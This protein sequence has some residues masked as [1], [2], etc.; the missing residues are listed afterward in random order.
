MYK[1]AGYL[2]KIS[3]TEQHFSHNWDRAVH[4]CQG[5]GL[6]QSN[7]ETCYV[8]S[9]PQPKFTQSEPDDIINQD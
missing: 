8:F 1:F 4:F 5:H 3:D 9:K 7:I 6:S 2:V